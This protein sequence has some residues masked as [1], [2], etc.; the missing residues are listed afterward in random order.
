MRIC[1]YIY[2]EMEASK[3]W[4]QQ[5]VQRICLEVEDTVLGGQ[6]RCI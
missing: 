4:R 5:G 2:K 1:V 6:M 3:T